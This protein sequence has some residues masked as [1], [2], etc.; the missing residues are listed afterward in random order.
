[1][2]DCVCSRIKSVATSLS[3]VSY[4]AS[5]L[6]VYFVILFVTSLNAPLLY[7]LL[8]FKVPNIIFILRLYFRLPCSSLLIQFGIRDSFWSFVIVVFFQERVVSLSPNPLFGGSFLPF[9][10][11]LT[12]LPSGV[13]YPVFR[14]VVQVIGTTLISWRWESGLNRS[15]WTTHLHCDRILRFS[16]PFE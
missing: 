14:R 13:G 5:I 8:A 2:Q 9:L 7:V 10:S 3:P 6:I 11:A 12:P 16:V 1:M 15:G 4:T